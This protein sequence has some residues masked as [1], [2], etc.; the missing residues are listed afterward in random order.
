MFPQSR[1]SVSGFPLLTADRCSCKHVVILAS[2]V[3]N[4]G[5][6]FLLHCSVL[7]TSA[8]SCLEGKGT[9]Q[10]VHMRRKARKVCKCQSVSR[11]YQSRVLKTSLKSADFPINAKSSCL[12]SAV[13]LKC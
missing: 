7:I 2:G 4:L 5:V 8:Y 11:W 12:S 9:C 6:I 1:H 3:R 13:L 10:V